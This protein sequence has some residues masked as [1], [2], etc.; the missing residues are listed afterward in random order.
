MTAAFV[1]AYLYVVSFSSVTVSWALAC[2][3]NVNMAAQKSAANPFAS[4]LILVL[5]MFRAAKI[6]IFD[7]S[8]A[9]EIQ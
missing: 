3:V 7:E 1:I 9:K 5:L 4:F 2:R 6:A 8:E